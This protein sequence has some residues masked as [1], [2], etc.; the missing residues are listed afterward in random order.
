MM[1]KEFN[2]NKLYKIAGLAAFIIVLIIPIQI[3]IFSLFPPPENSIGFIEL[4]RNNWLL[5]LLSLDLLYYLNNALLAIFYLGLCVSMRKTDF[6]NMLVALVMGLIGIA[7]YYASS[8]GFEMLAISKQYYQTD[9]IEFQ[10]QLISIGHGLIL[11]YKG[12]AFDIYYV[13]NAI[14]LLLI[15]K[16]MFSSK[17]FGK[18]AATWGVIA[19]IFMIIPSTAGTIGLVF[20]LISLIPWIVFSILVGR[21]LLIMAKQ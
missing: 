19:G 21:K 5:G 11:K 7:I 15:A 20:S 4:F 9:S 8:V 13:F 3:V 2:L 18:V 16:T 6:T 12:T 1:E 10:Q 17:D 14:A